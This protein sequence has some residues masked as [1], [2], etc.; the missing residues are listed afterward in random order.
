MHVFLILVSVS[1][2]GATRR[3]TL[4]GSS[5]RSRQCPTR[6]SQPTLD[7]RTSS[8]TVA[9][10]MAQGATAPTAGYRST[11]PPPPRPP[12]PPPPRVLPPLSRPRRCSGWYT[13]LRL[14][15]RGKLSGSATRATGRRRTRLRWQ[16]RP[17][18]RRTARGWRATC[19]DS[20]VRPS[21]NR[22]EQGVRTPDGS[23]GSIK[24]TAPNGI[25]LV[26]T[27]SIPFGAV[28]FVPCDLLLAR[29]ALSQLD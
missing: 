28:A 18:L 6:I 10:T 24:G 3:T 7:R 4:P 29:R 11:R 2:A 15:R 17:S 9:R 13:R 5:P 26:H 16:S 22:R 25:L 20:L 27:S 1:S 19:R 23:L 21:P 14:R 8:T 12:L